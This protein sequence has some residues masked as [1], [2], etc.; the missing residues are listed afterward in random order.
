[1]PSLVSVLGTQSKHTPQHYK[2]PMFRIGWNMNL[3]RNHVNAKHTTREGGTQ[4]VRTLAARCGECTARHMGCST[5]IESD[6]GTH[7]AQVA[8]DA[9]VGRSGDYHNAC[10]GTSPHTYTT[11]AHTALAALAR[12]WEWVLSSG[13]TVHQ[14]SQTSRLPSL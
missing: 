6:M 7:R 4:D 12:G 10:S 9:G 14:E 11:R 2:P 1:M 3:K 8:G 5:S 13:V